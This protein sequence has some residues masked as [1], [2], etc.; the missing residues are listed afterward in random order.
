MY[1]NHN[2]IKVIAESLD[3]LPSLSGS[4]FLDV[5]CELTEEGVKKVIK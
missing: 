1:I 3:Q 5:K 2:L 4:K